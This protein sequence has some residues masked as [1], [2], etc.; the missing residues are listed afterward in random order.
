M[1]FTPTGIICLIAVAVA[2][3][4][5]ACLAL[6]IAIQTRREVRRHKTAQLRDGWT[7][8]EIPPAGN[9]AS[10]VATERSERKPA[11]GSVPMRHFPFQPGAKAMFREVAKGVKS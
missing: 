10:S 8:S 1:T 3:L 5:V 6:R 4:A 11:G 2:A 7:M 9:P